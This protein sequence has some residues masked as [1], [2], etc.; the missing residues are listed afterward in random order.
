MRKYDLTINNNSYEVVVKK[1]TD[2][3]VLVEVNGQ[4]QRVSIKKIQRVVLPESVPQ[5]PPKPVP[6]PK[7]AVAPTLSGPGSGDGIIAPMPGQIKAILVR[8]GDKVTTGQKLLIMEAM[9][10]E[11]KLPANRDGVVKQILVRDG[12]IVSQGQELIVIG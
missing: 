4:E 6:G 11:N 9:K 5:P 7:A 8:E 10:L 2:S 3:E 12:D 1:V